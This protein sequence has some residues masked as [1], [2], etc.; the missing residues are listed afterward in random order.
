MKERASRLKAAYLAASPLIEAYTA[1]FCPGCE[2]VCCIDR[3]GT[4]EAEDLAFLDALGTAGPPEP[5]RARDTLPCRHLTARGCAV[6]RWMRP[7][8]CTWYFCE[9]LL[10]GIAESEPRA[11]RDLLLALSALHSAR[12]EFMEG[13]G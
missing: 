8:R 1:L 9:R 6:E 13:L 10:L 7:Y 3:H 12:R 2:R 5:P 4:H 11:Y